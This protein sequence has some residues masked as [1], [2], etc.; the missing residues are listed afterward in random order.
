M[1]TA[2]SIALGILIGIGL[3][4]VAG[5]IQLL[6]RPFVLASHVALGIADA[7]LRASEAE[8]VYRKQM[9]ARIATAEMLKRYR[10]EVPDGHG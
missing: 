10:D 1:S 6:M 2:H 4:S 3:L 8:R 9:E 7:K 5:F